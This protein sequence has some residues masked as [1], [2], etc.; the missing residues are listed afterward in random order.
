M[1]QKC[2]FYYIYLDAH[3]CNVYILRIIIP[4]DIWNLKT[5]GGGGGIWIY[6]KSY[7]QKLY[8]IFLRL[9]TF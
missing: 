1:L 6:K 9:V 7:V 2:K 4:R 5:N 8:T 3:S